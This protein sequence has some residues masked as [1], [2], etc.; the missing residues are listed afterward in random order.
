MT[1]LWQSIRISLLDMRGDMRRFVLLIACL[2]V[3]TAL[4]AGVSSVGAS[5][6]QAV[7]RDAALLMGGD[8]ELSRA[9]RQA[10]QDELALISGFGQVSYVV[11]TNVRAEANGGEAFVDLI[12][13]GDTYPLLG[14]VFSPEMPAGASPYTFL[15]WDGAGFGALVDPLMLD[16]LGASVGD[17]VVIGGT[18]FEVRG[19]LG[20]VPDGPVRGFR[21]RRHHHRSTGR[22]RRPHLAAAR[23]RHLLPLQGPARRHGA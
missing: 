23:S 20:G 4:I 21:L 14:Q 10:T 1:G 22:S 3:G 8:I 17:I 12:S 15:G 18:P 9:D 2:A 7:E 6:R 16:Q 11:D 5:I 13:V 19:R